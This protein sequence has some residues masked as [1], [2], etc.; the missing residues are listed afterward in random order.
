[1]RIN[2]FVIYQSQRKNLFFFRYYQCSTA[3][4][5]VCSKRDER[6]GL[7]MELFAYSVDVNGQAVGGKLRKLIEHGDHDDAQEIIAS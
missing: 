2:F 5:I 3:C 4:L 7:A 6:K 1:M